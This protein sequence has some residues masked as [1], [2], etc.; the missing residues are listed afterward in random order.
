MYRAQVM[1]SLTLTLFLIFQTG[2]VSCQVNP[3]KTVFESTQIDTATGVKE[4][5]QKSLKCC[6]SPQ[7]DYTLKN[8]DISNRSEK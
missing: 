3:I 8:E 1:K 7:E 4:T 5:K 2:L 6:A